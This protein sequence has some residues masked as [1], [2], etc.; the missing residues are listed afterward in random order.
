[1]GLMVAFYYGITGFA[2]VWY[3]RRS[4]L[5]SGRNF[6]LRGMLPLIGSIVLSIAF[7]ESAKDMFAVGY[8]TTSFMGV[9]GVFL[10]GIGA[11]LLG[12]I[13]ME[14]YRRRAPA[15]FSGEVLNADTHVVVTEEGEVVEA[16][17]S[18]SDERQVGPP[19]DAPGRHS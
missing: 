11:L 7:L 17:E 15:Y 14:I 1:M 6:L 9:G 8:G 4:L 5:K 3:F 16:G 19:K 12:V 13:L 18:S 10:I 2:C